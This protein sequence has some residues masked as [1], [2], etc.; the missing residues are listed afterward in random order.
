MKSAAAW[1]IYVW[2]ENC[3]LKIELAFNNSVRISLKPDK[4][5]HQQKEERM[6]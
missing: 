4:N 5:S 2:L 3:L 1:L 6:F